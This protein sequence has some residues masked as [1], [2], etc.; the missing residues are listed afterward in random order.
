MQEKFDPADHDL[1]ATDKD[2]ASAKLNIVMQLRKA[3]DVRGNMAITF[4]DGKKQKIPMNIMKIAL[5]KFA[6]VRKPASK[7]KMQDAMGKSYKDMI[8][9][10]KTFKEEVE[11]D[12]AAQATWEVTV[13]KGIN[14]LKKGQTVKVKARNTAEALTKGAKALGDPMANKGPTGTL[15]VKKLNESNLD[16]YGYQDTLSANVDKVKIQKQID[17]AE[18]YM[19]TFFGNTSSVKM[20]KVAI[21]K[22]IEKLK[23]QL[24]EENS[25]DHEMIMVEAMKHKMVKGVAHISK[26]N[27][28]KTHNDFK[29]TAKGKESLLVFDPKRGTISVPVHFTEEVELD[30][31]RM[32]ELHGY[33]SKGKTAEWIAKKMGFDVKDIQS[34]M[35]EEVDLEEGFS[36]REVKMA[37]GVASDKRYAGGNMTGAINAIEKIKKGLSDQPQVKAVLKRQN[38]SLDEAKELTYTVVHAKKGKLV[39]KATT[40]YDAAMKG[41]KQWKLK[42]T[43]GIDSHLMKEEYLTAKKASVKQQKAVKALTKLALGG[44]NPGVGYTSSVASNGDYVVYDGGMRIMGRLAKGKFKD[45]LSEAVKPGICEDCGCEIANPDPASNCQTHAHDE[46]MNESIDLD[47]APSYKLYHNTFS[48]AVQEAIAVAK[49]KG[50][51]VDEDDWSNK[52]ATGPRKPGKDKTNSYSIKLLKNGKAVKQLLQI[53]VYN[54]GAKYELNCYV[55]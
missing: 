26:A 34:L 4:A 7:Q 33:I 19:K 18:K 24:K 29:G 17:Q 28:R 42:S 44:K 14:K 36:P 15:T 50:F 16:E 10:L 51:D 49:K 46:K 40:S 31:G 22:K 48:A 45:P 6:G 2:K 43:A 13:A 3:M 8:M 20:K 30:E 23:A 21:Q 55:Q 53:Q 9:T 41:A 37:I 11:L 39:V 5:D 1:V 52:V 12:E 47:E 25:L 54:M 27:F 32:K 35:D 38:E